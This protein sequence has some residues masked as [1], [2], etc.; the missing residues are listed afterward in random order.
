MAETKSL[1]DNTPMLV[2]VSA[3]LDPRLMR[4]LQAHSQADVKTLDELQTVIEQ[5]ERIEQ[6]KETFQ[7]QAENNNEFDENNVKEQTPPQPIED[8]PSAKGEENQN[9]NG[10]TENDEQGN[11]ADA[12]DSSNADINNEGE[13]N[14]QQTDNADAKPEQASGEQTQGQANNNGETSSGEEPDPFEADDTV[15]ESVLNSLRGP[16]TLKTLKKESVSV[17]NPQTKNTNL[18]PLK[19]LS[20]VKGSDA[21]VD[22]RTAAVLGTFEDPNNLVVVLDVTEVSEIKAKMEFQ[23]LK[24]NLQEKG[25]LVTETLDEAIDYLNQVYDELS[26]AKK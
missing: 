15:F 2:V 16:I 17:D 10:K 9:D 8:S 3:G 5:Q 20:V 12:F 7:D 6:T 1:F 13:N 25:I 18:P 19:Q 26:S 22:D 14:E 24:K 23:N 4:Q 21:G 11:S